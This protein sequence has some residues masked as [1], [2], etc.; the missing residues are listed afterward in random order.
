MISFKIDIIVSILKWTFWVFPFSFLR[1]Q[2]RPNHPS[3]FLAKE[4]GGSD[5]AF[6]MPT[7]FFCCKFWIL[8]S[9]IALRLEAVLEPQF[10][11]SWKSWNCFKYFIICVKRPLIGQTMFWLPFLKQ[12]DLLF[13]LWLRE[14]L[15]IVESWWYVGFVVIIDVAVEL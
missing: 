8:L 9:V 7:T 15:L 4:N 5:F 6:F 12:I 13:N 11:F 10:R 1:F 14:K 2:N 3:A